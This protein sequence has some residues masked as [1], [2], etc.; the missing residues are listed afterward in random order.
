MQTLTKE[1]TTL[2]KH[3][4]TTLMRVDNIDLDKLE[5]EKNKTGIKINY[6]RFEFTLALN[7]NGKHAFTEMVFSA[8][9]DS[10]WDNDLVFSSNKYLKSSF[11][12]IAVSSANKQNKIRTKNNS[13]SCAL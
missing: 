8:G 3:L 4:G 2:L 6:D 12:N 5:V 1:K 13:K 10:N 9:Y 11:L 7:E